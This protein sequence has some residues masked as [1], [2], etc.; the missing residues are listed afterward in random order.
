MADAKGAPPTLPFWFGE[1]PAR[2]QELSAAIARIR[3]R[4]HDRSWLESV[5]G[6]PEAAAI[7]LA[8]YV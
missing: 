8:E 6:L 1:A 4:G 5:V 7:Q 3:E 2:T